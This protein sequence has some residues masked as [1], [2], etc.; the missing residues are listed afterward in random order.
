M[1]D[2]G[3][4]AENKAAEQSSACLETFVFAL[5]HLR[6]LCQLYFRHPGRVILSGSNVQTGDPRVPRTRPHGSGSSQTLAARFAVQPNG[7]FRHQ[8][9]LATHIQSHGYAGWSSLFVLLTT[10][11]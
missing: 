10:G 5:L 9:I 7:P 11:S 1:G 8:E 4:R 2:C 3:V 6:H